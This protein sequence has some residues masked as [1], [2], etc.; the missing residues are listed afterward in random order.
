MKFNVNIIAFFFGPIYLFVL[1]LWKRNIILIL[2][3][4]VVF[5]ALELA[6]AMMGIDYPRHLDAGV[7]FGFNA[8][9]GV[10]TNYGYYLKEKKGEQGWSPFKGMRW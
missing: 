8:L 4:I 3:M 2:L 9:Y 5:T 7:G 6:F 1:G 10:S